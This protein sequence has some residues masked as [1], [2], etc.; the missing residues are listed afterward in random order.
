MLI[1]LIFRVQYV[2]PIYRTQC[3]SVRPYDQGPRGV[4]PL[5]QQ[6]SNGAIQSRGQT[7]LVWKIAERILLTFFY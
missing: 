2:L 1:N 3:V 4:D 7:L 5:N 6:S